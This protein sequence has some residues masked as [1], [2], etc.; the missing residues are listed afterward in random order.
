MIHKFKISTK[1]LISIREVQKRPVSLRI[2]SGNNEIVRVD[3]YN[4]AQNYENRLMKKVAEMYA[5]NKHIL[6][7][8]MERDL[9]S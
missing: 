3:G 1:I 6:C 7:K 8:R 5:S 9:L 4:E 2:I